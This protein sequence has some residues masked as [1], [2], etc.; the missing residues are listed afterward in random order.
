[1]LSDDLGMGNG[2]GEV[3]ER[4]KGKGVYVYIWLIHDVVQQKLTQHFKA[5]ILQFKNY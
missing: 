4:L 1:M 2:I 3:G 5:V